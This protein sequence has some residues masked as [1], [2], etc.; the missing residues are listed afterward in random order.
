MAQ[1]LQRHQLNL[2]K[3]K[4]LINFSTNIDVN[5]NKFCHI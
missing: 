5:E 3:L 4:L 1:F 2:L